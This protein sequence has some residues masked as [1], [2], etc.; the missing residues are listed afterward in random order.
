[1]IG[2]KSPYEVDSFIGITP[3]TVLIDD[4]EE[5]QGLIKEAEGYQDLPFEEK[6]SNI[7]K[8]ALNAMKNAYEGWRS[9]NNYQ[10]KRRCGDIVTR[11]HP[12]GFALK[13]KAGCCRYQATLFLILAAQAKLGDKHY[14]Q[15]APINTLNTCFNDVIHEGKVHHVSIFTESL[16]D[17]KFNY[18]RDPT[19][20]EKP[21]RTFSQQ[22]FLA[23]TVEGDMVHKYVRE[24]QHFDT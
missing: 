23:Y 9:G 13:E 17:Q 6:L 7:K 24:D 21:H 3:Y 20:F 16:H 8:I 15:S 5:L 12:L 1:M 10:E 11:E 4:T 22:P 14:L 18:S 19:I 2:E